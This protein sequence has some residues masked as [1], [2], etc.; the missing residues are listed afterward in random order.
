MQAPKIII[1]INNKQKMSRWTAAYIISFFASICLAVSSFYFGNLLISLIISISKTPKE[2]AAYKKV[3]F[4]GCN[5]NVE[6]N[7]SF[8]NLDASNVQ[9]EINQTQLEILKIPPRNVHYLWPKLK[10]FT[11]KHFLSVKSVAHYLQPYKI[12]FHFE[13]C[14]PNAKKFPLAPAVDEGGYNHYWEEIIKTI[15]SLVKR[16]LRACIAESNS[17]IIT[18]KRKRIIQDILSN[19][20][21]FY[22]SEDVVVI[23]RLLLSNFRVKADKILNYISARDLEFA[24]VYGNQLIPDQPAHSKH[25]GVLLCTDSH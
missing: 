3:K 7:F 22:I 18:E 1:N 16:R 13:N 11:F 10:K 24:F 23:Q 21:G 12:I 5:D 6:W 20:G 2:Y 25:V 19:E 8:D 17:T 9:N 4:N 15:P 14:S